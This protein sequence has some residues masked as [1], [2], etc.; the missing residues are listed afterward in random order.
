MQTSTRTY[1]YVS[2]EGPTITTIIIDWQSTSIE[3]AFL[4]QGQTQ[5]FAALPAPSQTE[6][7]GQETTDISQTE[8]DRKNVSI[9]NQT[10]NVVMTALIPGMRTSRLLDPALFSIFYYCHTTWTDSAVMLRRELLELDGS[11]PC[12]PNEEELRNHKQDSED[13][14]VKQRLMFWLMAN[15]ETNADDWVPNEHWVSALEANRAAYRLWIET[16][17]ES[18]GE[19]ELGVEKADILWPFDARR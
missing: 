7:L 14:E 11:C 3:P 5:T 15:I 8:R 18:E 2:A 17:R 19:G 10:Y 4:Y 1:K 12:S 13:F 9:F 16:A 6:I